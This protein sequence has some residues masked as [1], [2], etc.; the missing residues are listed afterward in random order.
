[1]TIVVL[2]TALAA[3]GV[4]VQT[5]LS[6]E[7]WK[8]FQA[9]QGGT[10]E[11]QRIALGHLRSGLAYLLVHSLFLGIG[12]AVMVNSVHANLIARWAFVGSAVLLILAGL[13]DHRDRAILRRGR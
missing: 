10:P 8:S 5:V 9:A 2:W 7:S 1:M 11:M 4:I 12:I 6:W 13:A 3:A